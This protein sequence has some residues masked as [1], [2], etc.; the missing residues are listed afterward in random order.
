MNG[1]ISINRN[2]VK[3]RIIDLVGAIQIVGRMKEVN[4]DVV[5][6]GVEEKKADACSVVDEISAGG[7]SQ[8]NE[9][10]CLWVR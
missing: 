4:L 8:G 3:M 10:D 5:L 2:S 6:L 7:D 9:I 1:R